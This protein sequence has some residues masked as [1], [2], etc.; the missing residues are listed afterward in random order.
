MDFD[1]ICFIH[2]FLSPEYQAIAIAIIAATRI[3]FI[4]LFFP[5]SDTMKGKESFRSLT[6]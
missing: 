5:L 3:I 1:Q 6:L 4:L 2:Y